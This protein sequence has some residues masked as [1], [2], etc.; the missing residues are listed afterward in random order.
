MKSL[1]DF[2]GLDARTAPYALLMLRL[3]L[4]SM[5]ISHALLKILVF[6]LPGAAGFLNRSDCLGFWSIR[7]LRLR[8]PAGSP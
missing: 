7:W 8:L 5:W 3:A 1:Y 2:S 4:G 6:T